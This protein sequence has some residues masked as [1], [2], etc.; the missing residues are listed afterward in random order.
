MPIF[1]KC[2]WSLDHLQCLIYY[3]YSVNCPLLYC[4]RNYGKEKYVYRQT[5]LA[6]WVF[7]I[8][9]WLNPWFRTCGYVGLT[10]ITE[11]LKDKAL[12]QMK[13]ERE[14]RDSKHN[15]LCG[16][17]AGLRWRRHLWP[18]SVGVRHVHNPSWQ[19]TAKH[20]ALSQSS[21]EKTL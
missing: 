3:K 9:G 1:W 16:T 19:S 8:C 7:S 20:G 6:F 15:Q 5:Q 12:S 10:A 21:E 14:F 17:V 4:L 13:A 2:K 18:E 11:A